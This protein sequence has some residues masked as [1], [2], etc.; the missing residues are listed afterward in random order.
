MP[1]FSKK[2]S[3]S[4]EELLV[5]QNIVKYRKLR[6]LSQQ[7]LADVIGFSRSGLADIESGKNNVGNVVLVRIAKVLQV[8]SD[9]LLGL[10]QTD[11]GDV[12]VSLRL[13][14][15]LQEIDKLPDTKKK[16]VLRAIDDLLRA[17]LPNTAESESK[18][19]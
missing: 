2:P 9:I 1:R 6:G 16:H 5:N 8:S 12:T 13:A 18:A 3:Q 19:P 11:V 15:R 4:P 14:R 10:T 17:N 7:A